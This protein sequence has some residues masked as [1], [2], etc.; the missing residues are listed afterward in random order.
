MEI[1]GKAIATKLLVRRVEHFTMD[2]KNVVNLSF[3]IWKG[4]SVYT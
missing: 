4:I 2:L 3:F 1:I